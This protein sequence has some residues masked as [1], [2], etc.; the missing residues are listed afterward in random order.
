LS[1]YYYRVTGMNLVSVFCRQITTFPSNICWR[2]YLF[3]IIPKS[4]G[5]FCQRLGECSCMDSY[6]GPLFCSTDFHVCFSAK[7]MM[8]F[9]LWL[10]SI[11]W[12]QVL[13]YFQHCS[14]CSVLSWLFSVFCVAKWTLGL[15]FQSRDECHWDFD[16]NCI[17]H[18]DYFWWYNHFYYVDSTNLWAW[19][20]SLPSVVFLNLF[21]QWFVV[22]LIEVIYILYWV[23]S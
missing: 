4:F 5:H 17:E 23:Y 13:W 19:E 11:V 6:P 20:I 2:G 14:F 12:S 15:I 10:C 3:P 8:F 21:L 18:V 22:L 9:L 16:G 7:T 1:W